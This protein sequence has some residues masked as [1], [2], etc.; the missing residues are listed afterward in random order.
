MISIRVGV[1]H[2]NTLFALQRLQSLPFGFGTFVYTKDRAS[3]PHDGLLKDYPTQSSN[4]ISGIKGIPK[5]SLRVNH[6]SVNKI[7]GLE[8]RPQFINDSLSKAS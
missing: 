4:N 8:V 6:V 7:V 2:A 5:D 3:S 1:F